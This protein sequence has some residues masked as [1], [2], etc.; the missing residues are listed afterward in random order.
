[1]E[2]DSQ[3]RGKSGGAQRVDKFTEKYKG[4]QTG[5]Y[6]FNCGSQKERAKRKE[7]VETSQERKGNKVGVKVLDIKDSRVQEEQ[8]GNTV[9]FRPDNQKR[10]SVPNKTEGEKSQD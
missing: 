7:C 4:S 1:M 2:V 9:T 5:S 6:K 10:Y 3:S 8:E